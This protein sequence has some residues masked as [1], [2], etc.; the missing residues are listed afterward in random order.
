M[1]KINFKNSKGLNLV[2][3]LYTTECDSVV[4]MSHGFT[5]DKS[6]WGGI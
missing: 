2:G 6:E 5:G 3:N 1:E 4:I